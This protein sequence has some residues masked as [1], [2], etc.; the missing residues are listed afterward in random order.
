MIHM[1][2]DP[3]H[4]SQIGRNLIDHPRFREG[5]RIGPYP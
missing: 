4:K 3:S 1:E 5:M 2:V